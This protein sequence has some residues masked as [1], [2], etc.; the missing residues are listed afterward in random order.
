MPGDH[1]GDDED[2]SGAR[3]IEDQR[4][5]NQRKRHDPNPPITSTLLVWFRLGKNPNSGVCGQKGIRTCK[6]FATVI[7]AA[8]PTISKAMKLHAFLRAA[9]VQSAANR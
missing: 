7:A 4:P 2:D 3:I 9:K 1:A 8:K 6:K 5:A